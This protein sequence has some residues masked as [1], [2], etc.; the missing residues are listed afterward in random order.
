MAI[1]WI[2]LHRRLLE[3]KLWLSEPF[4][5]GQA[6][7]DLLL[8][9][10]HKD[11]MFFKRGIEIK[12]KRGM[13]AVSEKGLAE[14]WG[15]SRTKTRL[16]IKWLETEHQIEHQKN[17]VTTLI[18]IKNYDEYQEKKTP[19]KTPKE[20]QKDTINNVNNVKK[21]NYSGNGKFKKPSLEEVK[22]F[23]LKRKNY[24]CPETFWNFYESKAW[25]IGKNQMKKW[26]S[27]IITWEQ[28]DKDRKPKGE[29]D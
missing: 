19:E 21:K 15:W 29:F 16:F 2:Q 25:M 8:L 10:S 18:L 3:N 5:K 4:T 28:K 24:V 6:W 14:R 13:V 12:Q 11:T 1:G 7:V 27:A 22:E 9:A 26:E 17:N 20:H 23:C